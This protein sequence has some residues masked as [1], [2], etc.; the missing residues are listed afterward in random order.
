MIGEKLV[1]RVSFG[2][3]AIV[4]VGLVGCGDPPRG[5]GFDNMG[6]SPSS[7]PGPEGFAA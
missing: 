1:M 6:G 7:G 3:A 5:V 2:L 4:I